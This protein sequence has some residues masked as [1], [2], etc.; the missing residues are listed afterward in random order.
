MVCS[1]GRFRTQHVPAFDRCAAGMGAGWS[2]FGAAASCRRC[3]FEGQ[4]RII[5]A[6]FRFQCGCSTL[7]S[8]AGLSANWRNSGLCVAG[9]DGV[10]ILEAIAAHSS[11][12]I[13]LRGYFLVKGSCCMQKSI[14]LVL[15]V[16]MLALV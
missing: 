2:G 7:L 16:M 15:L 8:T 14:R 1:A 9:C 3:G 6:G 4:P 12:N 5:P 13:K 10:V 11:N